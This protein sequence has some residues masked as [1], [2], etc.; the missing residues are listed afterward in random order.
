MINNVKKSNQFNNSAKI[1]S[2]KGSA[3]VIA[4]LILLL[5]MGFAAL[6]ISRTTT[7]I[8]MTGNDVSEGRAYAASEASLE[9]MTRDFVDIFERKLVPTSTDIQTIKTN[10]VAGFSNFTFATDITKTQASTPTILTGGSYSGLYALRDSWE[11]NSYATETN[12]DVKVQLKRR[13]YSD[14]DRK[15]VV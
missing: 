10:P 1:K 7:E 15:S 11:V 14:R 5:L 12:S 2:E 8:Q 9:S 13:F 6:A 4:L 3:L